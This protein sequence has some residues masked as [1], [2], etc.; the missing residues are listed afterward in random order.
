MVTPF[1]PSLNW[2]REYIRSL[3]EGSEPREASARASIAI[4][5]KGKDY[6]RCRILAANGEE[7]LGIPV[8]GGSSQLK[9]RGAD[10]HL[11]DHG[12][13]VREH[14]GAWQAAYG[15]TPYYTYLMPELAEIYADTEDKSL[16]EFNR[17][18]LKVALRWIEPFTEIKKPNENSDIPEKEE[19]IKEKK[20]ELLKLKIS[21]ISAKVNAD[22]SIFDALFRLG[23]EN[24][25]ALI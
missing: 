4:G 24:L 11:S 23:K 2:V 15:K 5:L 10:P 20:E 21:E 3:Q 14:L 9:R 17:E 8:E 7:V 16:E 1:A 13:W 22:L 25:F 12:K 19:S 6:A 18:I